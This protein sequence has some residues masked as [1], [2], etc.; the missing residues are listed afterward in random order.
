MLGVVCTGVGW[1]LLV[2]AKYP[3]AAH[4]AILQTLVIPTHHHYKTLQAWCVQP[5]Q[6]IAP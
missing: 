5:K 4:F 6:G 1:V 2:S 3:I